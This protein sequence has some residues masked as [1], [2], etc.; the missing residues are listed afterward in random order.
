MSATSN[1]A[2]L[3]ALGSTLSRRFRQNNGRVF[4]RTSPFSYTFQSTDLSDDEVRHCRLSRSP[5][6]PPLTKLSD[7]RF[8]CAAFED[9]SHKG[10]GSIAAEDED[11]EESLLNALL[12][13]FYASQNRSLFAA[14]CFIETVLALYQRGYKVDDLK[15]SV[16]LA[17][18]SSPDPMK[19]VI[20]DVLISWMAVIYMTL[21]KVELPF[22]PEGDARRVKDIANKQPADEEENQP[23]DPMTQGLEAF[24]D[25]CIDRYKD[26]LDLF[27]L[28]LQQSMQPETP[29]DPEAAGLSP[30]VAVL[31]HNTRLVII[32]LDVVRRMGFPLSR[33]QPESE[34]QVPVDTA[35]LPDALP[36][37]FVSGFL[38]K[39]PHA[40]SHQDK[41]RN[42]AIRL[43]ICFNGAALGYLRSVKAFVK[44]S[45]KCYL[46]GW[47]ADELFSALQDEEFAQSGGVTRF[48]VANV[49]GGKNVSAALFARWLSITFITLAQLGIPHPGATEQVGWAWVCSIVP[50]D[51]QVGGLEAHGVADF[52]SSTLRLATMSDEDSDEGDEES[53]EAGGRRHPGDGPIMKEQGSST[54]DDESEA[55]LATGFKDPSLLKTSSFALVLAQQISLVRLTRL[56]ILQRELVH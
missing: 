43:L 54:A 8:A 40:L 47:T 3:D 45:F 6:Y 32:T 1:G 26:G 33:G 42:A 10:Q 44:E 36:I 23:Q 16:T 30:S 7:R 39:G 29:E 22:L 38:G 4:F 5:Y 9:A 56:M 19:P 25:M 41:V 49:P 52:V 28:Q 35:S 20:V 21:R 31:Q 17:T 48:G 12:L 27:R 50:E 13:A 51:E 55:F 34:T 53:R 11:E 18:L 37:G 14:T 2:W 46:Q 15:I 24:V